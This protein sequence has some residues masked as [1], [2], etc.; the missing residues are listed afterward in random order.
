MD[1]LAEQRGH[2]LGANSDLFALWN[3][4]NGRTLIFTRSYQILKWLTL[5]R[6]AED[7]PEKA[8]NHVKTHFSVD[9][10]GEKPPNLKTLS[11]I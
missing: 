7:G 3:S 6:R 8:S 2:V 5:D 11:S 10:V 4:C 1:L 9:F